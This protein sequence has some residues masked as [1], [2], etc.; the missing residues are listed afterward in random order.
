M[1]ANVW[2]DDQAA[3]EALKQHLPRLYRR[4]WRNPI[5]RIVV[6]IVSFAVPLLV[7]AWLDNYLAWIV[8]WLVSGFVLAGNFNAMHYCSH[9]T[10][11]PS[12]RANRV[13]GV[14]WSLPIFMNFSL[15]RFF[16]R[17]HHQHT[18]VSGDPE[19][20]GEMATVGAYLKSLTNLDFVLP[21]LR[22]SVQAFSGR[23]P[24]FVRTKSDLRQVKID[25]A[26]ALLWMAL[27]VGFLC[28]APFE[29]IAFYLVPLVVA[30][31]FNF[32]MA[33]TE[34][35]GCALTDNTFQ[36]TRTMLIQNRL[37]RYYYWNSNY[38]VEH[39]LL[40]GVPSWQLDQLHSLINPAIIHKERSYIAFQ[41]RVLRD[42]LARPKDRP[43]V[44]V[45]GRYQD[46]NYP[47][48]RP[49]A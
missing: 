25:T 44:V 49:V 27:V 14:F 11:M 34:H 39:H 2:Q 1:R 33:L 42:I 16:H 18:A 21:F 37:L 40:P 45:Q 28:G 30:Y 23:A 15:Y 17:A 20:M 47:L 41:I 5:E 9:D 4:D 46:F 6:S 10:F 29:A 26:G 13:F 43:T 31:A 35:Y 19:P 22:M 36:S 38:H 48:V 3:I 24:D 7:A 32:C 12:K 8:A